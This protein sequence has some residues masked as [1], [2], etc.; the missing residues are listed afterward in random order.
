VLGAKRVESRTSPDEI[1]APVSRP[2]RCC[3]PQVS[4]QAQ[5]GSALIV[6]VAQP[7]ALRG[8]LVFAGHPIDADVLSRTTDCGAPRIADE[9]FA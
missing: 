5:R 2:Q 7:A 1:G 3:L 9:R 8:G 4:E 6:A